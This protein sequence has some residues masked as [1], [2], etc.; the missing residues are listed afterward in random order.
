MF[1]INNHILKEYL[2]VQFKEQKN[3]FK[4]ILM[5]QIKM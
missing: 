5:I 3:L 4:N 1:K 2:K